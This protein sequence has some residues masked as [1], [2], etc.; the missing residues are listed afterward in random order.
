[1]RCSPSTSLNVQP[2]AY[3]FSFGKNE[4]SAFIGAT[5]SEGMYSDDFNVVNLGVTVS[6]ELAITD[7]FSL[8]I[9]GS[10]IVNPYTENVFFTFGI[11]L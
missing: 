1:M 2:I 3:N 5:P 6:K 11:S 10:F 7:K 9:N 4:G 8:P